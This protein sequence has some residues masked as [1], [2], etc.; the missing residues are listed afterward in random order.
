MRLKLVPLG[1]SVISLVTGAV[2]TNLMTNGSIPKL[3]DT[4]LFKLAEKEITALARGEDGNPRMAVDTFAKKVV[5]NVL[6]SA[7]GKLWRG[8]IALIIY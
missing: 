4:S 3:S 1:I 5:N 8:Q 6:S 2:T 7:R